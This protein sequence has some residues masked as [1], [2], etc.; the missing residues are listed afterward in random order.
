[1]QEHISA[2]CYLLRKNNDKYELLVIHRTKL[3]GEEKY[4]LP[5]GHVEG[6]ETLEEAAK[7]ETSEETGY[8]DIEIIEPVATNDYLVSW[9]KDIHKTDHYFLA[10]LKSEKK[11]GRVLTNAESDSGMEI[12]W[13]DIEKGLKILSWE[14]LNG[15]LEKIKEY[16][17][18]LQ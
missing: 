16:I 11:V 14:N 13:M 15:V 17:S 7:R 9:N 1:M 12:L 6:K 2:G 5:K 10:I 18:L 3:Q 4:V 8:C